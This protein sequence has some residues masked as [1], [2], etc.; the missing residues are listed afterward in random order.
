[1]HGQK[2]RLTDRQTLMRMESVLTSLMETLR[3]ISC[4]ACERQ[5]CS[6]ENILFIKLIKNFGSTLKI[7]RFVKQK[8]IRQMNSI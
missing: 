8:D 6:K 4:Y 3:S 7:N 5:L 1:M 2:Y